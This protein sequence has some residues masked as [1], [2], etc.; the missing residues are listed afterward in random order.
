LEE[1][2]KKK[3]ETKFEERMVGAYSS[4]YMSVRNTTFKYEEH[5]ME[6]EGAY[7]NVMVAVNENKEIE[8]VDYQVHV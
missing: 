5:E 6:V 2:E 4:Y 1:K 7:N 3:R 8:I